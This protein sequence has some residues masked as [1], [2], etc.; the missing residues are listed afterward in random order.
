MFNLSDRMELSMGR[1]PS[2]PDPWGG[3][4]DLNDLLAKSSLPN[5]LWLA[6]SGTNS[7][8]QLDALQSFQVKV[9][10]V[11][12]T[13]RDVSEGLARARILRCKYIP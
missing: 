4:S 9:E 7:S 2:D 1:I 12:F 11:G 10:N 8:R 6:N 5:E 13:C 3:Y